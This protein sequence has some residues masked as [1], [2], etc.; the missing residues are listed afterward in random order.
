MADTTINNLSSTYR[1]L[2]SS[3][4]ESEKQPV[5][6]LQKEKD[7]LSIRKGVYQDLKAKLDAM[8]SAT[9]ALISSDAFFGLNPGRTV[10]I[11]NASTG[12]TVASATVSSS[13]VPASY[14]LEVTTL[15]KAHTVRSDAWALTNQALQLSGTFRIGGA[16]DRGISGETVIASTV[17]SFGTTTPTSGL[18][19]LKSGKY[20]VETQQTTE[21]VWQFRVLDEKGN[22]VSIQDQNSTN[23]STSGWQN[24]PAGGGA[25]DTGRGLVI[26]LGSD[27]LSYVAGS[28]NVNGTSV[29]RGSAA[30]VTYTAK[31]ASITVEA[32]D[33]LQGIADKI[34]SATYA[35]G[36]AVSATIINK[37]LVLSSKNTGLGNEVTAADTSGAVLQ[38]LGLL[39]A[40]Q[41]F[42]NVV[43]NAADAS[44]KINGLTVTRSTN[45]GLTDVISG[46]T[47]NL[48]GD[49]EGKTATINVS[50][51]NTDAV[52]VVKSFLTS[53]NSLQT[54]L[55]GK[56]EV[57][58]NADGTYTRGSLSGEYIFKSLRA[59]LF[60]LFMNSRTN[61]GIYTRLSEIGLGLDD[62]MNAVIKD[63]SK[64]EAALTNDFTNVKALLDSVMTATDAKLGSFTGDN[65]YVDSTLDS[66]DDQTETL[67]NRINTHN[68]RLSKRQE[69]LVIQYAN[70]Q[71]QMLMMEYTTQQLSLFTA[72]MFSS[73]S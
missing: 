20:Y 19:E 39:K 23:L 25:I 65:R 67:T 29:D 62:N 46:V 58:K 9:R 16:A 36:Q 17:E 10:G 6:R 72:Q 71:A 40:D 35:D 50:S 11:S 47:L 15:A 33:T 5:Y 45:T 48:A 38:T 60:G 53:F 64:L 2:I 57:T 27:E 7:S 28:I 30:E 24:I 59:D 61:N 41:T 37:Q 68:D 21:G 51:S 70:L 32:T 31:G 13:A 49:A 55:K 44:F 8:Q 14:N 34:N 73:Y 22:A 54:Y 69:S 66:I 12:Y 18:K 1:T 42:K 3:I 4:I 43:Q 56:T 52:G 63:Q 26:N